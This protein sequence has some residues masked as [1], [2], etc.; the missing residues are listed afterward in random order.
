VCIVGAQDIQ[1]LRVLH[2]GGDEVPHEALNKSPVCRHLLNRSSSSY[3]GVALRLHFLRHAVNIAAR[4]GVDTVQ[5]SRDTR[6]RQSGS[7]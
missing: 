4:L 6:L 5:V 7:M 3:A 2:L 1:P